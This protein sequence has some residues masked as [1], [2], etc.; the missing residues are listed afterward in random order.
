MTKQQEQTNLND[1][2][3]EISKN[4]KEMVQKTQ[5]EIMMHANT[6]LVELYF[7]IGK[8]LST[9]FIWGNKFVETL[10]I[11]LKLSF[12]NIKGFSVR[13]LNYMK[14]FYEEYKEDA[15]ILQ[16]VAK[17]SWKNNL[18]LMQKVKDKNIRIWYVKKNLQ[19]GWSNSILNYQ[20]NTNLYTRQIKNKKHNNFKFTMK[21]NSDLASTMMKDPYVFD[22]MELTEN[23]KEKE[24]ENKMLKKL[25]NILLELGSGFSFVGN[26]YKV[27]VDN[28]DFYID[29]LFYHIHLKCYIAIELKVGK[30]KPE[31]GSKM[32]FYLTAL[33]EQVKD[34]NDNPSIG[35]ILCSSKSNKIVDYT[36]KYINKPVGVSEYKI[37]NELPNNLLK[38]FPT[39]DELNMYMDIDEE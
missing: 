16:L 19:E 20:I 28:H 1:Q 4:V 8:V 31:F 32:G 23:Y 36:L 35:I 14:A 15:E 30:F 25:K 10:A 33:D 37:F 2:F 22:L 17:L 9:N 38:D 39:E 12:P 11:E 21:E 26:Q 34:D 18:T 29:L 13:N 24:L 6:K 5:L 3:Q 7:N 27:V